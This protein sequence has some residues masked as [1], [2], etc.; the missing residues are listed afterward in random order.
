M[1]DESVL[2]RY[3]RSKPLIEGVSGYVFVLEVE[4][5]V[6]AC[7]LPPCVVLLQKEHLVK[8]LF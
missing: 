7:V 8:R 2:L 5:L 4:C 6:F 3:V 1:D